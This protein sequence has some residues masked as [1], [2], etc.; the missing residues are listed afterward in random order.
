MFAPIVAR[1]PNKGPMTNNCT[2][3][4]L[5][6]LLMTTIPA[7]PQCSIAHTASSPETT[8]SS[9]PIVYGQSFVATCDGNMQYFELIA[10]ETGT[11]SASTINVYSG[12]T[13]SGTPIPIQP[14]PAIVSRA[15]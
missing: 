12:H 3:P 1:N 10:D 11:I 6:V 8:A 2:F 5:A 4:L 15:R 14:H 7:L 13:T 9:F